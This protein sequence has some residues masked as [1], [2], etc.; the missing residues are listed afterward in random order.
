MILVATWEEKEK[1]DWVRVSEVP[2]SAKITDTKW[3]YTLTETTESSQS[4]LAGW[5][6]NGYRT[7]V[8]DEGTFEYATFPSGFDTASSIY[9]DIYTGKDA[10]P[11][12][13]GT[14][15]EIISDSMAGYIL[16]LCLSFEGSQYGRK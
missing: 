3:K 9:K 12:A 1:S 14:E 7:E 15:R 10:V 11:V 4:T 6:Y 16:A 13:S 5:I 8:V 2:T